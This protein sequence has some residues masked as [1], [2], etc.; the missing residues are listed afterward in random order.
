MRSIVR[1]FRIL[2][3]VMYLVI[4]P[5]VFAFGLLAFSKSQWGI[6]IAAAMIF[7]LMISK[8]E[9]VKDWAEKL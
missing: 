5:E 2:L 6:S 1:V 9:R 3:F 7:V 8:K 4:L